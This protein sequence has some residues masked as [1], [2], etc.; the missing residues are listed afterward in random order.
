MNNI[1]LVLMT[2]FLLSMVDSKKE[3]PVDIWYR[4]APDENNEGQTITVKLDMTTG[5]AYCDGQFIYLLVKKHGIDELVVMSF[6]NGDYWVNNESYW[7][8]QE[9]LEE[10]MRSRF[11]EDHL[12]K[13]SRKIESI[14]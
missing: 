5:F 11:L 8:T 14:K 4:T 12:K 10:E 13:E 7:T 1:L 2:V 3:E 6:V 9:V